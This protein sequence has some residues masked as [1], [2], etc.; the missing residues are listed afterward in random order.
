MPG[1][2][3]FSKQDLV[4]HMVK[5]IR[6]DDEIINELLSV[7][8]EVNDFMSA[9]NHCPELRARVRKAIHHATK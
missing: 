6:A 3:T 5:S 7:L 4:A 2:S 1:I 8:R 9:Y